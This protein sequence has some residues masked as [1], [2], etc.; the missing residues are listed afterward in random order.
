MTFH[1]YPFKIEVSDSSIYK[2]NRSFGMHFKMLNENS[3]WTFIFSEIIFIQKP[4]G[5]SLWNDIQP[6]SFR[7]Y[8]G[9]S[10]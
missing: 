7:I 8:K 2:I 4:L 6:K 1:L 5:V 9:W 10:L 3:T